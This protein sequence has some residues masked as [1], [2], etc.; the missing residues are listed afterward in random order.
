VLTIEKP[1]RI[2]PSPRGMKKH[3][4]TEND[5]MLNWVPSSSDDVIEQRI[6]RSKDNS[7]QWE[8]INTLDNTVTTYQDS[9]LE[10]AGYR[11]VI[12]AVDHVGLE[13]AP[14]SVLDIEITDQPFQD[15]I[16]RFTVTPNREARSILLSWKANAD[17][18]A[19]VQ[20]YKSES[21]KLNLFRVLNDNENNFEDTDLTINSTYWYGIKVVNK[22]GVESQIKVIKV[23]Y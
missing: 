17:D 21:E 20:L 5:V 7:E 8:L 2:P 9:N 10:Q 3:E 22:M 14:K 13:S 16:K 23:M 4:I 6:Y 18:I 12:L 1:D 15:V 19:E 11:Y